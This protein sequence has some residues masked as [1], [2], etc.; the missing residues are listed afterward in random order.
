MNLSELKAKSVTDLAELARERGVDEAGSMRKQDV[1]FALLQK[2]SEENGEICGEG[3]LEK[4]PDG[5]GFMRSPDSSYLAGPD[6]IYVSPSQIRRFGLQTGDTV[7]GQ[8]RPPKE[9]ERYFALL[10]V[11]TRST[12]TIRTAT[13]RNKILFDNLTPLYPEREVSTLAIRAAQEPVHTHHRSPGPASAKA[14]AGVDR[15]A[16]ASAGKT[17]LLQDIANA[18]ARPTIP[19]ST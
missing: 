19:R 14:S 10:K 2:E 1:I 16:A 13:K 11:E 12:A 7:A 4:L 17:M 15:L 18:I 8:I 9:G 3:V 5:Y 6:D